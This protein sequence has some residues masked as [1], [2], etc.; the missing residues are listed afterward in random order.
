MWRNGFSQVSLHT[1]IPLMQGGGT[2]GGSHA[3]VKQAGGE[4]QLMGLEY[5]CPKETLNTAGW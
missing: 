1:A 4:G 2:D 3:F 5:A